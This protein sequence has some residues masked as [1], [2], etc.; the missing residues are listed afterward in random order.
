[1][2]EY[3]AEIERS[4]ITVK[5][6]RPIHRILILAAGSAALVIGFIGIILPVLP[7]TPFFLIAASCYFR[8]SER[9]YN[10]VMRHR[11]IAP[12]I[13]RFRESRAI[14]RNVKIFTLV[15]AWTMLIL[16][17][18]FLVDSLFMRIL[19]IG[20]GILKTIV[21]SRIKTAS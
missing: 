13:R 11:M 3:S 15:F 16:A 12:H 20:L 5:P 8:S 9:L 17:A 19:F 2:T 14:S 1:M 10:W 7:S 18:V 21:M 6:L 4:S